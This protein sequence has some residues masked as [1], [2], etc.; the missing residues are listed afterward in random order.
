[1]AC[2]V[3]RLFIA[4]LL[5]PA[6]LQKLMHFSKFAALVAS[7]GLPFP[8][9]WAMLDV[10]I[11]VLGPIALIIGLWPRWTALVLVVLTVV[12]TWA[13]YRFGVFTAIFRASASATDEE[14]RRNRGA[15]VLLHEWAWGVESNEP[16]ARLG[17]I[18]GALLACSSGRHGGHLP[19]C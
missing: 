6:G 1:M 4:A 9:L 14:P 15:P 12:T 10:A 3:G 17:R 7:K 18:G 19:W 2:L 11:E 13:T 5:L 8:K 16:A